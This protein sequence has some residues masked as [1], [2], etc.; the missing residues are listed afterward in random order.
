MGWEL[1]EMGAQLITTKLCTG[2]RGGSAV[3]CAPLLQLRAGLAPCG[4]EGAHPSCLITVTQELGSAAPRR[5]RVAHPKQSPI[6]WDLGPWK[7]LPI[8]KLERA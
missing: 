7:L 5:P 3:P 1:G 6:P 4:G 2:A 8:P